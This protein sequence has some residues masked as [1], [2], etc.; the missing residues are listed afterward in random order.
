MFIESRIVCIE[1]KKVKNSKKEKV[2]LG[3][4]KL[5]EKYIWSL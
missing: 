1:V 3:E 2:L 5:P 4:E